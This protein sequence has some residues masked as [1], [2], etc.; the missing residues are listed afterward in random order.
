M[1]STLSG[2]K[3]TG[4]LVLNLTGR[5]SVKWIA[6]IRKT[7][8]PY[9]SDLRP[10]KV[11][12]V[13][14]IAR[15]DNGFPIEY[16]IVSGAFPEGLTFD[17]VT[18]WLTGIITDADG[19]YQITLRATAGPL[20]ADKI[21]KIAVGNS[22]APIW[23]FPDAGIIDAITEFDT[24]SYQLY[25]I[26][27]YDLPVSYF[28]TGGMLPP[29]IYLDPDT[30]YLAGTLSEIEEDTLYTFTVSASNQ[31]TA[32][33]REFSLYCQIIPDA[34]APYWVTPEGE[35]GSWW[36]LTELDTSVLAIDPLAN[37]I[38][39]DFVGGVLPPNILLT[40]DTGRISGLLGAVQ[41]DVQYKFI[42]K[43][44]NQFFSRARL[45][46]VLIKYDDPPQWF[47]GGTDKIT[48]GTFL[49]EYT[50]NTSVTATHAN[51]LG[52]NYTMFGLPNGI[53]YESSNGLIYGL[54]PVN[55]TDDDSPFDF[56][57]V[58]TDGIKSLER[59]FTIVNQKNKPPYWAVSSNLGADYEGEPIL[60]PF[61]LARD[62][63]QQFFID[64]GRTPP[65]TFTLLNP[66]DLPAE[67][68]FDPE[69]S[70]IGG[71]FPPAPFQDTSYTLTIKAEDDKFSITQ[72]FTIL[73]WFN[74]P[75]VWSTPT[76]TLTT[77]TEL[78]PV[79]T[80]VL[81]VDPHN[82]KTIHYSLLGGYFPFTLDST[83][84]H[85]S[86]FAPAATSPL[87]SYNFTILASNG[88]KTSARDFTVNVALDVPP[89]WITNAG[90]VGTTLAMK[91]YNFSWSAQ[92][93]NPGQ[94]LSYRIVDRGTLPTSSHFTLT[95]TEIT[96]YFDTVTSD[97]T[98]SF[99]ISVTDCDY[100][101]TPNPQHEVWRTFNVTCLRN[102]PPYWITGN[103]AYDAANGVADN[104]PFIIGDQYEQTPF[105][106]QLH[107]ADPEGEPIN[108]FISENDNKVIDVTVDGKEYITAVGSDGGVTGLL[109][110]IASDHLYTF[111]VR[112]W[113][114]TRGKDANPDYLYMTPKVFGIWTRFNSPPVWVTTG[115]FNK[116]EEN[117]F[118]VTLLAT[119]AGNS[120]YMEYTLNSG[121]LPAGI[122]L[123]IMGEL[124]GTTPTVTED[125]D[126]IFT[127][128]AYNGIKHTDKTFLFTVYK[129]V[130]PV[131]ITN[132]ALPSTIANVAYSTNI[133]AFDLNESY[134]KGLRYIL[135]D[136][137]G[138]PETITFDMSQQINVYLPFDD[139]N[140]VSSLGIPVILDNGG[141][142]TTS[143]FNSCVEFD[144]TSGVALQ[145][146][147]LQKGDFTFDFFGKTYDGADVPFFNIGTDLIVGLV[148]GYIT[149]QILGITYFT[150]TNAFPIDT[151]VNINFVKTGNSYDIALDGVIIGTFQITLDNLKDIQSTQLT[152]GYG[153]SGAIDEF[154]VYYLSKPISSPIDTTFTSAQYITG[155]IGGK[156][157]TSQTGQDFP[158][159][160]RADDYQLYV[161]KEFTISE[162]SNRYPIWTTPA[163]LIANVIERYDLV[164]S[165]NAYD[166]EGNAV[167]YTITQGSIPFA[168]DEVTGAITGTAPDTDD[169]TDYDF[170]VTATEGTLTNERSFTIRVKHDYPPVWVTPAGN[171]GSFLEGI[172]NSFG[173]YATDVNDENPPQTDVTYSITG[174][175][176][177]T[178]SGVSFTGNTWTGTPVG[179]T[180][181]V[182]VQYDIVASD[183][184]ND[185]PRTF[186]VFYE[187]NLYPT[188]NVAMNA[189]IATEWEQQDI[190]YGPEQEEDEIVIEF[191]DPN[192]Y[193]CDVSPH[194]PTWIDLNVVAVNASTSHLVISHANTPVVVSD[195][196]FTISVDVNDGYYQN[197]FV[198][199]YVVKFN[200]PPIWV[201]NPNLG[202][203]VE[204]NPFSVTLVA[205]SN[206]IPVD[207]YLLSGT[208]PG[209]L[210]LD[211]T[212][213]VL[214]GTTV[215]FV[216]DTQDVVFTVMA[217]T[218]IKATP[219][220]FT[221][222]IVKN[223]PPVWPAGNSL[224]TY[225]EQRPITTAFLQATDPNN[226][227]IHYSINASTLPVGIS[228]DLDVLHNGANSVS[229]YGTTPAIMANTS[230]TITLGAS[231]QYITSYK[232][233]TLTNLYDK[234]PRWITNTGSNFSE[235]I[236]I[237]FV[238][239]AVSDEG[240]GLTFSANSSYGPVP[241]GLTV[242]ANGHM[243]GMTEQ[244]DSNA[245]YNYAIDVSDGVK[246]NTRT[247][248]STIIPNATVQ[249]ISPSNNYTFYNHGEKIVMNAYGEWTVT[250]NK[251]A[252]ATFKAW[253]AAG[254]TVNGGKGGYAYGEYN[255][256][257]RNSNFKVW[258]GQ[259]GATVAVTPNVGYSSRFG[260]GGGAGPTND[261]SAYQGTGGGLSGIFANTATQANSILIAA[262]GGGGSGGAGGGLTGTNGANGGSAGGGLGA[263]QSAGG[264]TRTNIGYGG[265]LAGSALQGGGANTFR[266]GGGGGGGY[267]GGGSAA[268]NNFTGGGGGGGSGFANSTVITNSTLTNGTGGP[269]NQG[270]VDY[271]NNAGNAVSINTANAVAANG[272]V[273][274]SII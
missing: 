150:D 4:G 90:T 157:P 256:I 72:N 192:N 139:L 250:F 58:A 236:A 73:S 14:F 205:T 152:I 117:D 245:V 251:P 116:K 222:K 258:V 40:E 241:T 89:T 202:S 109:P 68:Y 120:P 243:K 43:A 167:T 165:V 270:D 53:T 62:P 171:V 47:D 69:T 195:T 85:I 31:S 230:Y 9:G 149:V 121:T 13:Q 182:F 266:S 64:S 274:I 197:T 225:Y 263:T 70:E 23:Q 211:L 158:F 257:P 198:Y 216:E 52:F 234:G 98:Y 238:F 6:P 21:I 39:Y 55:D 115:P 162:I 168:F 105:T 32:A 138:M 71:V 24:V 1:S 28:I 92:D 160:A 30:G 124:S 132:S 204:D 129:E 114:Q 112:A 247:F 48:L 220:T 84:G 240:F 33:P 38:T 259:G 199:N 95:P 244:L 113:D 180:A 178:P 246:T 214:S 135:L 81:A 264:G 219:R 100:L 187:K 172:S 173:I 215:G 183:G 22:P 123:D 218:G 265:G 272:L 94:A 34:D 188:S 143:N 5:P 151:W 83:T 207:Y 174:T 12:A 145:I 262:G 186:G 96:G 142:F 93:A 108:Y 54:M 128:T 226:Q 144:S 200:S 11:V 206:G 249:V 7:L 221:L 118:S 235:N 17:L 80:N 210:T 65:I 223:A 239:S 231:N 255:S 110:E 194:G 217:T 260:G 119:G 148:D 242:Y 161:D 170:S 44:M 163:G 82:K 252:D 233:Y 91:D 232:T 101:G 166:P 201:T 42:I 147:K 193:R 191:R 56:T 208:F 104:V 224:G 146:T 111:S 159:T 127:V 176:G 268:G 269:P 253:G 66:E 41:S 190:Y 2:L 169:F 15:T 254:G 46:S 37:G 136:R 228:V 29:G 50:F 103:V 27:V 107:A 267:W 35:I 67:M 102:D 209:D 185:V 181:D 57:V 16:S 75:P 125:T 87:D 36:E 131:W 76:G 88:T 155:H 78:F 97:T 137:T 25:A 133:V 130:A 273:V 74:A 49:E 189:N 154:K 10:S 79:S 106:F 153:L 213:G 26:D 203:V 177:T 86:G 126:Y 18:G 51:E 271:I 3:L 140:D 45:F 227:P 179:M 141:P 164:T 60:I 19:L 261:S 63:N 184:Y 196:S 122:T 59:D 99:T 248:S 61:P 156:F 134:G 212:T 229:I 77:Q 237:D 175:T 20:S 8:G